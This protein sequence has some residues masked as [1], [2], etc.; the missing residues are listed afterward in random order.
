MDI[1]LV[2]N[3]SLMAHKLTDIY[4]DN[5]KYLSHLIL[6]SC[7]VHLAVNEE[8]CYATRIKHVRKNISL[9]VR[10]ASELAELRCFG[11]SYNDICQRLISKEKMFS[12]KKDSDN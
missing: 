6:E 2:A 3:L 4:N 12:T 10:T 9:D 1:L 8:E 5:N 7:N 11:D